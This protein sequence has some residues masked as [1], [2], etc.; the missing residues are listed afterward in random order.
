MVISKLSFSVESKTIESVRINSIAHDI[1]YNERFLKIDKDIFLNKLKSRNYNSNPFVFEGDGELNNYLIL[2]YSAKNM[3]GYYHDDSYG[4]FT[5]RGE[6]SKSH[7]VEANIK[8][9]QDF[10]YFFDL[11]NISQN[12]ILNFLEGALL[13]GA[14]TIVNEDKILRLQLAI[15]PE[16]DKNIDDYLVR[17]TIYVYKNKP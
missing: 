5:I 2:F 15:S 13:N 9:F 12:E 14:N 7:F 6:F 8:N 1:N 16:K 11:K 17:Y 4:F 10:I 3:N